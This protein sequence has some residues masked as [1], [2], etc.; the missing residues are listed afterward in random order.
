MKSKLA[1]V[2]GVLIA[3]SCGPAKA[4]VIDTFTILSV[5]PNAG[6]VGQQ[7][8]VTA[9][10]VP[11]VPGSGAPVGSVFFTSNSLFP[12]TSRDLFPAATGDSSH[13]SLSFTPT[14]EG[15]FTITGTYNPLDSSFLSSSASFTITVFSPTPVPG[16][17]VGAGLPGLILAGGILLAW[18]QRRQKIA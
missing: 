5:N 13:A 16:P 9:T 4:V 3:L 11:D 14:V 10:V 12:D 7:E 6:L 15:T 1:G 8:T 17:I 18:W 2:I